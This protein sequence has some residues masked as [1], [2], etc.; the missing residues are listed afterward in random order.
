MSPVRVDPTPGSKWR[1]RTGVIEVV[2]IANVHKSHNADFPKTVFYR[3]E[4]GHLECRS[5]ARFRTAVLARV[6]CVV[7]RENDEM[8]CTTCRRR[9]DIREQGPECRWLNP[10]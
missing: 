6:T 7:R 9:W 10:S 5:I 2:G 4:E 3:T 8:V 1:M